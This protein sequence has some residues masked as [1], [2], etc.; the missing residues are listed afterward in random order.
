MDSIGAS[1][2]SRACPD[3][4]RRWFPRPIAAPTCSALL[5]ALPRKALDQAPA[6]DRRCTLSRKTARALPAST[7][8]RLTPRLDVD[9]AAGAAAVAEAVAASRNGRATG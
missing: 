3:R 5:A 4:C 2:N 8:P 9:A 7:L 6:A 1:R